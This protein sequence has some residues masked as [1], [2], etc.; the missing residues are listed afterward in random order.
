MLITYKSFIDAIFPRSEGP[1]CRERL[2]GKDDSRPCNGDCS[3]CLMQLIP[4]KE[5]KPVI[6]SFRVWMSD[7]IR[8][9]AEELFREN[10]ERVINA[11]FN[12]SVVDNDGKPCDTL[13][14]ASPCELATVKT[15]DEIKWERK[16][17]ENG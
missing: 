7:C 2:F 3:H 9:E 6:D 12:I 17:H 14:I 4:F 11:P 10:I 5:L 8:K 1:V 15:V 13:R 16:A